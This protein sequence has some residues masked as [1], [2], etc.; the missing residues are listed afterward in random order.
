MLI[1]QMMLGTLCRAVLKRIAPHS[2]VADM[3]HVGR[4][5]SQ[6]DVATSN[7]GIAFKIDVFS[8]HMLAQI[9]ISL[10]HLSPQLRKRFTL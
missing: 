8:C 5:P 4:F 7:A 1:Y 9:A 6:V 3:R 2:L 10:E